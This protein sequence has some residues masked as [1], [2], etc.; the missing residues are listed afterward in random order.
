MRYFDKDNTIQAKNFIGNS[1]EY[2]DNSGAWG[3]YGMLMGIS[4]DS[5]KPFKVTSAKYDEL[6]VW[7][8]A[9]KCYS[10]ENDENTTETKSQEVEALEEACA[11]KE[12]ERHDIQR[13]DVV[14][15]SYTGEGWTKRIFVCEVEGS[16]YPYVCVCN[17]FE[18]EFKNGEPFETNQWQYMRPIQKKYRDFTPSE[19]VEQIGKEV[20][21]KHHR[22]TI[23]AVK[24]YGGSISLTARETIG[25]GT[26]C[27]DI[28]YK[29]EEI[30]FPDGSPFGVEV[31]E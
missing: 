26:W 16:I 6:Y 13:G 20:L 19:L 28:P 31:T 15:A 5:S 22:H 7:V 11:I 21:I 17:G 18:D 29:Q 9:V 25:A 3:N 14:E 30:T 2:R 24:F 12:A 1:I 23:D 10:V 8:K 27:R 4:I